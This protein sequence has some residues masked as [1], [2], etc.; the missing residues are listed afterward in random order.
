MALHPEDRA[1]LDRQCGIGQRRI[2][3]EVRDLSGG[4]V[5]RHQTVEAARKALWQ[6]RPAHVC[7][8]CRGEADGCKPCNNTGRVKKTTFDSGT[9]AVGEAA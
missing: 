4:T 2:M 8:Y 9:A 7:P 5:S 3:F 1:E 6:G